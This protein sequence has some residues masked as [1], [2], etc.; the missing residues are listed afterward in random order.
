MARKIYRRGI[1]KIK[2]KII[3]CDIDIFIICLIL[4]LLFFGGI[5][6]FMD[7]QDILGLTET[8]LYLESV[9]GNIFIILIVP[10]I[11]G[12]LGCLIEWIVLKIIDL[13][14]SK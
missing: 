9:G 11:G 3:R 6:F 10:T 13:F 4:I 14:K 12:I 2:N 7:L 5:I 1:D 8:E